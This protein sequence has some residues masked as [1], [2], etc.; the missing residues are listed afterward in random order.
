MPET[1][2]SPSNILLY[3]RKITDLTVVHAG[4]TETESGQTEA[5]PAPTEEEKHRPF[6]TKRKGQNLF[7]QEQLEDTTSV[8]TRIYAFSYEGHYYDLPKPVLFLV[9][10][11]GEPAED[12]VEDKPNTPPAA[13]KPYR[14]SRGPEVGDKTGIAAQ[15]YSFSEDMRVWSYDKG[16]FSIRLDIETGTFEQILLLLAVDPDPLASYAGASVRITAASARIS[17]ASARVAGASA[18]ISGASARLRGD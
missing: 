9:H 8:L 6:V 18:R 5:A 10:G 7:L 2:L 13:K 14:Q 3:G 17:G 11:E 15:E 4:Q 1:L 12:L 16:D